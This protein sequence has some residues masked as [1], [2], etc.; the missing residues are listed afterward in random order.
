MLSFRPAVVIGI[1]LAVDRCQMRR[2]SIEIRP[3]DTKLLPVFIDPFPEHFGRSPSLV[4]RPASDAHDIGRKPVAIAAAEAPAM[5]RPVS[6]R[7]QAACKRLTVVVAERAGYA[8]REPSLLRRMERMKELQ[9]EVSIHASDH[10]IHHRQADLP[11]RLRILPREILIDEPGEALGDSLSFALPLDCHLPLLLHLDGVL[12]ER[13]LV[14]RPQL[15]VDADVDVHAF[16]GN[17]DGARAL[18]AHALGAHALGSRAFPG[19]VG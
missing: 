16:V 18:G 8:G 11:C 17:F 19:V 15:S 9:L 14:E 10:V 5:V 3:P 12:L 6:C 13:P 7:S 2:I 1:F 4:P